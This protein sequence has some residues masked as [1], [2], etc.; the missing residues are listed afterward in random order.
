MFSKLER[1][2][3]HGH[4]MGET[5]H[6]GSNLAR[7]LL[8]S[9]LSIMVTLA[10]KIMLPLIITKESPEYLDHHPLGGQSNC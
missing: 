6:R 10:L 9:R 3:K 4:A 5:V 8:C 7:F 1:E 2:G